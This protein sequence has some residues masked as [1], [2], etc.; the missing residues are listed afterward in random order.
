MDLP[1][2]KRIYRYW[3]ELRDRR[4][5]SV[6]EL[7]LNALKRIHLPTKKGAPQLPDELVLQLQDGAEVIEARDIDDL[8]AQLRAR[9]P[10]DSHERFLRHE[11]DQEAEKRKAAALDGL[12]QMLARAVA[13]DLLRPQAADARKTG[14]TAAP[15]ARRRKAPS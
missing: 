6:R 12:V 9:Y 14:T 8:A 3:V 10:D 1:E 5:A 15:R 13:D 11:R 4:D 7:P 2:S